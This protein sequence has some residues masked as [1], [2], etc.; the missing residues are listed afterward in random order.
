M[1]DNDKVVRD[2]QTGR[3]RRVTETAY[4]LHTVDDS[5]IHPMSKILFGWTEGKNVGNILFFLV[6]GLSFALILLDL[7]IKRKEYVDLANMTGFYALWGFGA[8]FLVVLA[9]WPLGKLLRSDEDYYGDDGG[10]PSDIDPM[11]ELDDN[12][13]GAH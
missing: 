6:G 1:S 3:F 7:V 4:R 9:G 5:E 11:A 10:P 12:D 13:G 2:E 8:F